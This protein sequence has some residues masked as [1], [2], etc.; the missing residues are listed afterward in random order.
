MTAPGGKKLTQL[1]V[2]S[3]GM[4]GVADLSRPCWRLPADSPRNPACTRN[5]GTTFGKG[6]TKYPPGT[7][8]VQVISKLDNMHNNYLN[9]GAFYEGKTASQRVSFTLA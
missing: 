2:M 7:C 8:S 9:A 4:P 5:T 3:G 6:T 1:D